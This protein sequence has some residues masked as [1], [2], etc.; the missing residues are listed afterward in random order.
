VSY[1]DKELDP[2][3]LIKVIEKLNERVA[4]LEAHALTG[5]FERFDI[6]ARV[7][8]ASNISINDSTWTYL[9][10][11]AERQDTDGI[12]SKTTNTGR[13]TCR[14]PGFYI[15]FGAVSFDTNATGIRRAAIELNGS[16]Y[17]AANR[18]DTSGTG[19]T[20]W[21]IATGYYLNSDD[22]VQLAVYQTSG[23]ALDVVSWEKGSPEF[24]MVRVA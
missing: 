15:I 18:F 5:Q 13:L 24:G 22:Y 11:G 10:F 19:N 16:D 12:H 6:Y 23:G 2:N 21:A 4:I 14:T 8:N 7:Y 1:L 9:T 3:N 17:I 20:T